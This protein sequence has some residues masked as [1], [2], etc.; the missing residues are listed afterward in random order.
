[1]WNNQTP[2][3]FPNPQT[4]QMG[5]TM[6]MRRDDE[7]FITYIRRCKRELKEVEDEF[8]KEDKKEKKA[9]GMP[10]FQLATWLFWLSIPTGIVQILLLEYFKHVVETAFK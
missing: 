3:W 6:P 1:M 9:S 4:M 8:K 5:Y 10:V 2:Y 7:D